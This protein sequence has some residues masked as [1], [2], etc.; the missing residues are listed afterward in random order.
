MAPIT[1]KVAR[2]V[3]IAYFIDRFHGHPGERATAILR[4]PEVADDIFDHNDGIIDENADGEDQSE[5]R[6]PVQSVSVQVKDRTRV[7]AR[8]TG[9]A[10]KTTPDSRQP[11]ATGNEQESPRRVAM[12]R[13]FKK[14]I[15]L[16]FRQSPR[17]CE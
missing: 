6:D 16:I 14:L 3:G 2:M 5:Q 8:V 4:Q 15:G 1:A 11:R 17:N 9:T 10:N 13:C 7:R 12:N